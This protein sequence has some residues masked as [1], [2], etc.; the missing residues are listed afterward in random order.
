MTKNKRFTYK[1]Q[2]DDFY[3]V[4]DDGK[5]LS[6]V[7]KE[8]VDKTI[9]ILNKFQELSINDLEEIEQLQKE[10]KNLQKSNE[11][12]QKH[13]KA[14]LELIIT[15]KELENENKRLKEQ[16][17]TENKSCEKF[18]I[19]NKSVQE[20]FSRL[21]SCDFDFED[22][23]IDNIIDCKLCFVR[24][25]SINSPNTSKLCKILNLSEIGRLEDKRGNLVNGG[26][27]W[28]YFKV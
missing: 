1:K 5:L 17:V 16:L 22:I 27:G 4:Y 23:F 2:Y 13:D 11:D 7:K 18:N 15:N 25:N 8:Y 12:I 14:L 28:F 24:S 10:N 6:R 21:A 3:D 19:H 26:K 9:D 20:I